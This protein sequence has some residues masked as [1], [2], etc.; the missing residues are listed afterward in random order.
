M[1]SLVHRGLM[2]RIVCAEIGRISRLGGLLSTA[3][4]CV[5]LLGGCIPDGETPSVPATAADLSSLEVS[6]G[7]LSPTFSGALASYSLTVGN[8]V[9]STTVKATAVQADATMQINNQ[10]AQSGQTFG[11]IT[12]SV[13]TTT[14]PIVVTPRGSSPK[15]Y[16]VAITRSGN[17]SLKALSLSAGA[18]A[19]AFTADQVDY[20]VAAPNAA[21]QTTITATAEDPTSTVTIGGV[22]VPSG[23]AAGPFPLNVG[24]NAFEI[25]VRNAVGTS[26]K[27]YRVEVT[28]APSANANLS[29]LVVVPG[30]L[31]PAFSPE[32]AS[33][34][35]PNL[36]LF[37]SSVQ[38]Q[39]TTQDA[40]STLTVNNQAVASGQVIG[41]QLDGLSTTIPIVVRAQ[42]TV[43]T[44]SYSVTVTRCLFFFG[45]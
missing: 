45:C 9:T 36:N 22:A 6:A 3:A 13:G 2:R 1:T 5:A 28:R 34:Q 30:T 8:T 26:E 43:T 41:V 40:T 14:I 44:K 12:L 29:S 23:Q 11:P 21:A 16:T 4:V 42:D 10:P 35:V 15:T 37:V 27:K 38:V 19:P 31:T 17:V 24:G 33:Y 20:K 39:A 32:V 7:A 18:L 25:V